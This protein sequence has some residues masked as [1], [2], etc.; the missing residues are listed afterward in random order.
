MIKNLGKILELLIMLE[1]EG[2]MDKVTLKILGKIHRKI[3]IIQAMIG[4]KTLG[5][6]IEQ[7]C[8]EHLERSNRKR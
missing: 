2:D 1:E 7:L 6:A 8:D 4:A 3:R 5:D